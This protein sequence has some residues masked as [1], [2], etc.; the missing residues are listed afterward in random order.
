MKYYKFFL[1]K[2]KMR[3]KGKSSD[4]FLHASEKERLHI[5]TKAAKG[6]N[7]EQRKVFSESRS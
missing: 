2:I 4:S 3:G 6:A 5:L 7:E 1:E